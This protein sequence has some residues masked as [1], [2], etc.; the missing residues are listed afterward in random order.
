M[1]P[2]A[3]VLHNEAMA[4]LFAKNSAQ[5][6]REFKPLGELEMRP[7]G[8]TDMGNFSRVI[9]SIHSSIG[10]NSLP[11][12]NHQPEFT[13]HCITEDADKA[14]IDG[15]LTM[16]WMCIDMAADAGLREQLMAT[17]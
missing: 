2:Y 12:V 7:S 6:G 1:K 11:A 14:L 10:I 9:P 17:G 16:A 15:A 8:S 13:T 3:E 4:A 5:L